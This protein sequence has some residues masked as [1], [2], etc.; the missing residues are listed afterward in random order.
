MDSS[1]KNLFKILTEKYQLIHPQTKEVQ[2]VNSLMKQEWIRKFLTE[3]ED[4]HGDVDVDSTSKQEK[5]SHTNENITL[6]IDTLRNLDFQKNYKRKDTQEDYYR[7]NGS[8][9][10]IVN[11]A[12]ENN[13][14]FGSNSEKIAKEW[15]LMD[16][17]DSSCYDHIKCGKTIEQKS[18]RLGSKGN[19]GKFQHIE[20]KHHWDYLLLCKLE[21]DGFSFS[22]TSRKNVEEL[23]TLGI[24][25]GQGKKG[26]DG[27]AE[28]QQAY[29][30]EKNDFKKKDKNFNDYFKELTDETSLIEYIQSTST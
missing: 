8:P 7:K 20:L 6:S 13:K 4:T 21:L 12:G 23:V 14:V 5:T 1:V 27:I 24:I 19:E 9:S 22:I 11:Y 18:M 17:S 16:N 10:E 26:K 3:D 29:W 15:F 30:F 28:A 2:S 25:T